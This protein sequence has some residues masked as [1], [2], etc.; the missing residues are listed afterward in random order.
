MSSISLEENNAHT[1]ALPKII[2]VFDQNHNFFFSRK[3][4]LRN[5]WYLISFLVNYDSCGSCTH[6]HDYTVRQLTFFSLTPSIF[7]HQIH[8]MTPRFQPYFQCDQ[9]GSKKFS[10]RHQTENRVGIGKPSSESGG[11][12]LM[13]STEKKISCRIVLSNKIKKRSKWMKIDQ[14]PMKSFL[15]ISLSK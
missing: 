10:F 15:L 12:R 4:I 5:E 11:R 6:D 1:H 9:I 2:N 13:V 3:Q 14:T 7:Y 8:Y